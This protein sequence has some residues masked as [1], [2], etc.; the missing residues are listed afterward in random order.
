MSLRYIKFIRAFILCS[1]AAFICNNASAQIFAKKNYP[2]GYFQWPVGAAIGIAANFGELR[3]NHYHMGLDCRTDQKENK[4]VYAAADG[5]IAKIKIEPFGFGRS[6]YINH[7]NGFTTVYAH[8]NAFNPALEKYVTDQQ[9]RLQ[10]WR[11]F[12][13]MPANL[14]PVKKGDFIA[15][16][17]NTGGSQGPHTHFE[18]RDTKSDKNLNPLLFGFPLEDNIAPDLLRLAIYDR[19]I[20]TYDQ[21]PKIYFLKKVNGLYSVAGGKIIAA[22]DK[23]SFAITAYDRYA[24]STNQNG[25]YAAAVFDD[26]KRI[27]SFELDSISYDDTRYINAHVDYKLRS[28]GGPWL[29]YLSPLP[30]YTSNTVYKTDGSSGI[31]TLDGVPHSIKIIAGDANENNSALNFT[32]EPPVNIGPK[33]EI[34]GVQKFVPDN[35]NVFENADVRFYLPGNALY[36]TVNFVY[37]KTTN[38]AGKNVYQLHNATVPVHTYFTVNIKEQFATDDTGK[39]VMERFYGSKTDYKKANYRNGWYSAAFREFGN[40]QLL[41]DRV[42]PSVVP[43]GFRDG[44]NAGKLNRILFTVTDNTEELDSFTALLDGK[45]LRFSNDKGRNFIYVFDDH[46]LAGEH[47][48]K[49]TAVDQVGNMTEKVYHFTR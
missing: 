22:S 36:D 20:S 24:G 18:I 46:C 9:Y 21:T 34:A 7:P 30:G 1:A 38:A 45:W 29:Q 37:R 26:D 43:V 8:L 12:L 23:V 15:S 47:E 14:F 33:K 32:L 2:Q 19:S 27:S 28:T 17:G 11:V 6:I 25:I 31:I 5:Y 39:I 13:E 40:Y 4:P 48:L 44:M 16:S 42:P 10:S 49:V 35:L 3:P 41:I